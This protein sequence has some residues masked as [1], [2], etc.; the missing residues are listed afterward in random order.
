MIEDP[1]EDVRGLYTA[2]M[3]AELLGISVSAIRRWVRRD[4]LVA[5]VEVHRVAYL[6][7]GELHVAR[8][9]AE[10]LNSGCS[11]AGID[12]KMSELTRVLPGVARPLCEIASASFPG[13]SEPVARQAVGGDE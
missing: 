5:S 6:A 4:Y 1:T 11:L 7:P 2:A 12:T 9:L 3:L 10:I 8:L 13:Y